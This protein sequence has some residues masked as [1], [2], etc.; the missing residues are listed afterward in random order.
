MAWKRLPVLG[1]LIP[2]ERVISQEL[3]RRFPHL[4][5]NAKSAISDKTPLGVKKASRESFLT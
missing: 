5:R 2:Q 3:V 4:R 1:D